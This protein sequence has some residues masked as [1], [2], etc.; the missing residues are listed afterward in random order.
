MTKKYHEQKL[1]EQRIAQLLQQRADIDYIAMMAE[2]DLPED[3]RGEENN[4]EV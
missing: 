2:I 1:E 4:D 3:I